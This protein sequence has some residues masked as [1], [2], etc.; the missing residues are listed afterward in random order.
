[1]SESKI[2]AIIPSEGD[3]RSITEVIGQRLF[4]ARGAQWSG[5]FAPW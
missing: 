4:G 1:V 2:E 5:S 3:P